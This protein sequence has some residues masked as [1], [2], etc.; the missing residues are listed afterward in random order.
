MKLLQLNVTANWGST[1]KIA[2]GIGQ[3]AMDR[4]WESEIAYGRYMNPSRS[5]LIKVGTQL[6]VYAHYAKAIVLDGEGFGS[7]RA[8]KKLIRRIDELS[9]D[10]IHLHNIHDH[11]LNYPLLFEYFATIDTPIV[12]TFHDC[13]A[14]TGG[15]HHF[16]NSQ[17][18]NWEINSCQKECPQRHERAQRNFAKRLE[19]FSKIGSRLHVVTVSK[20]LADY[21]STSMLS[22]TN[23]TF[24]I[25]NNGIDVNGV[26]IP[27]RKKEKMILGVSNVWNDEKGL[28]DFYILRDK[29][30]DDIKIVLVGLDRKQIA[31]LPSG[32]VGKPRTSGAEELAEFYRKASVFVNPTYNDSFPTVNLEALA[33]G[34]PVITYRTGGSPEAIDE[35]TGIVVEKGNIDI[36]AQA[37][38]H[39][40]DNPVQ[41]SPEYCRERAETHFNKDIQFGKYIDLYEELTRKSK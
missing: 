6:D 27:R 2:E 9:P 39:I 32:I 19:V 23:A 24:S 22:Q 26:F 21:A 33:C 1:G 34:T 29:L 30:D 11:W 37:V 4:G 18:F 13:W 28:K 16:E 14:F 12:W 8:T 5:K 10:I 17:C 38:N 25:I 15:C 31:N 7:R 20:W 36:L 40:L 41:F 35:H 3:S